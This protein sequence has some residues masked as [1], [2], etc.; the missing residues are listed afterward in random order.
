M[1]GVLQFQAIDNIIDFAMRHKRGKKNTVKFG[2]IN[3]FLTQGNHE[4]VVNNNKLK[5][6][7]H[8]I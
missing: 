1:C 4:K 6:K 7:L 8:Y 2:F 5:L 3:R